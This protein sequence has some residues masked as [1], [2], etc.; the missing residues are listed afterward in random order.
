MIYHTGKICLPELFQSINIWPD[1]PSRT[2]A[3]KKYEW[4]TGEVDMEVFCLG[5]LIWDPFF[6]SRLFQTLLIDT[7]ISAK[8]DECRTGVPLS[9]FALL[10]CKNEGLHVM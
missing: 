3:E 4:H 10:M 2:I 7:S 6:R 8:V 1:W 5:K 9:P